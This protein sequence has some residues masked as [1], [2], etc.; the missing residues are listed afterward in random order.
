MS[1]VEMCQDIPQGLKI[2]EWVPQ[3]RVR[4]RGGVLEVLLEFRS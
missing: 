2:L 1:H 3:S 4:G